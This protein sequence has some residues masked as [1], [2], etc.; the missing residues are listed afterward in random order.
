MGVVY[1]A[2]DTLLHRP[3]ALKFLPE[4]L[5]QDPNALERFRREA[6]SA[7]ALN[8]P[9]ICT[10]YEF[11]EE[12]GQVFLA[13]EHMDGA[14]LSESIA[15]RP[16][17]Q[18]LLLTLAIE[19]ADALAAAHAARIIHRDIKPANVFVTRRGH[20]KIL[21][22][23]LAKQ[24]PDQA[25]SE[26]ATLGTNDSPGAAAQRLTRPGATVGTVAYMS[27]EQALAM[28]LDERTDLFSFG[29]VLYEMATGMLPFRGESSAAVFD[30]ILHRAPP[31]LARLNPDL[32][33]ELE[34][35][36]L[37]ALE[38]DRDL[39]YQS[40]AEIRADLQRLKRDSGVP[41]SSS[42]AVTKPDS[43]ARAA[44]NAVPAPSARLRWLLLGAA[45]LALALA[46]G[47]WLFTARKAHA[48]TDK[49]TIVLSDF[50]N[51]T[52]DPVFDGA[53]RQGLSV[54]LEQSPFLRIIPDQQ[55][56]QTLRMM[57]HKP[58]AKLTP[59]ISREICQ[60]VGSAAVLEGSIA[61]VGSQYLLTLKAV[62]CATGATLASTDA[63]AVDKNHI[64]D[65]LGK[66][67]SEMRNK[68][69]ESL[70]TVQKYDTPLEQA[71]TASLEALKALSSGRKVLGAEG[72]A[73][74][75]PF[76][77]RAIELDPQFALAYAWLGRAYGDLGESVLA[78][79]STR[80]AYELRDRTSEAEN[81]FIT[82]SYYMVVTGNMEKARQTCELSLQ[83]YPRSEIQ[84][85]F[86]AGI[87]L[88]ELGQYEKAQEEAVEAVRLNPDFP[89]TYT[90]LMFM[91][92]ALGHLDEAKAVNRQ[93]VERKL[94]FPL[95][96]LAL[97]QIA[98]LEHDAPGMARQVAQSKGKPGAED[99]AL[100][101][102]AESAAYFG[103]LRMA[104]DL[105]RQATESAE[106]EGEKEAAAIYSIMAELREAMFGNADE[107]HRYAAR[108]RE[109]EMRRD[110]E[111]GQALAAA[112]AGDS[113]R[114]QTLAGDLA[115]R[116]PEDTLVHFNYL[117][118]VR[119]M[120]AIHRGK[121]DEA[122]EILRTAIPYELGGT[123]AS[124]LAWN[125]MHPV[126][127][128]GE[129]YLAERQGREA[130]AEFQKILDHPGIVVNFPIGVLARLGLARAYALQGDT[131][132]ARAAYQDFLTLWK[133]ADP[134]IPVLRA[135]RAEFARLH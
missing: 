20:A 6:Q 4:A 116:F 109:H 38:K 2:E 50:M 87:I 111:Y 8:H 67:A 19:I 34:R 86:L 44:A 98:F 115:R 127:V 123:S 3:V 60:R 124:I 21:D 68:L 90:I 23:G 59:E 85:D 36:I 113:G 88:P 91:D 96:H 95:S 74:G 62:Q 75:I 69:G 79:D 112:F 32:P 132:K 31:A 97:Y 126:F 117:P 73:A 93:A 9:N 108:A 103:R 129:A 118:T 28:D 30:A 13:M 22:F 5:A 53:L 71:T 89:V 125:V 18:Q 80:K 107:L 76:F 57:G 82:A 105:S 26:A 101:L 77:R 64:L 133:D 1:K 43:S 70:S 65:A 17:D 12:S 63:Q 7:S 121:P 128:R 40:A 78:A 84:R 102:E 48:L 114:A 99:A 14:P 25:A 134:D 54:Q 46:T 120:L 11:G 24:A 41:A 52:G 131:A 66:T 29:V 35:V 33:P 58:D 83:A 72:D 122:V 15:G 110:V 56:Q 130:A 27:P 51:T 55:V 100:A 94:E 106:H 61:Q 92:I 119:A 39:R 37:K 135:A 10:V 16:L 45:G 49:D 42:D 104:R 47:A 81:Y